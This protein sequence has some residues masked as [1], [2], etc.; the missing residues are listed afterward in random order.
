MTEA[1][2][3]IQLRSIYALVTDPV[4]I[5]QESGMPVTKRMVKV[6]TVD[7]AGKIPVADIKYLEWY[8]YNL[9]VAGEAVYLTQKSNVDLIE[10]IQNK[11]P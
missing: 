8:S 2:V 1:E 10:D 5:G 4:T 6:V 7:T 11:L 3:M 9:G